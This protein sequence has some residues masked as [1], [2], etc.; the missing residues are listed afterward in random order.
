MQNLVKMKHLEMVYHFN[1][2]FFCFL[3]IKY[4]QSKNNLINKNQHEFYVILNSLELHYEFSKRLGLTWSVISR[5]GSFFY[6]VVE[7]YV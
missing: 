3:G 5:V 2:K 6:T 7:S 1:T 4:D